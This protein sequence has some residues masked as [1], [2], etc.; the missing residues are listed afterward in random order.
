MDENILDADDESIVN[1]KDMLSQQEPKTV[2]AKQ[3]RQ[4][5]QGA[6]GS[7]K[8]TDWVYEPPLSQLKKDLESAKPFRDSQVTRVNNWE[9][10]REGGAPIAKRRGK[11]A[12][13]PKLVRR[14]AE[15]RYSALSEPFLSSEDV[16]Q[17][18]PR[19]HE[20][21]PAAEQNS[22]L[23][24]WQFRTKMNLVSTIN[25]A[26]RTF[27]DE[28]TLVLKPGWKREVK[29][30]QVMMPVYEYVEVLE[31]SPEEEA[32]K[33]A[34]QL[35]EANPRG[36]NEMDPAIVASIEFS[37]ENGMTA[38]ARKVGENQVDQEKIVIN[39]PTLDIVD[40]RNVYIDPSCGNDADKAAFIVYSFETS[41]AELMKDGRYKNLGVVNYASGEVMSD[42]EHGTSTPQD[43]NFDDEARKR[44][45]AYEYWGLCDINNDGMLVPIVATWID[46]QLIRMEEN[47]YPDKKPPFLF[48]S[49]SPKKKSV[50]G[51]P[52]A[53]LLGDNQAISGA[54]IRGMI[55]LLG[56][57]ANSQQGFQKGM[58]DTTNRR[59]FENGEDYEFNPQANPNQA[60]IQH[61]YP[62]LPGSALELLAQ[63]NAEA[64]GLT[65][66]K[67]FSGGLSGES[68]GTVASGIKGI[69]DAAAKREMDIL[70]RL[71]EIFKRAAIKIIAMNGVFLEEKEVVR[72]TNNKFVVIR[73]DELEGQF[74]LVVDIS[75]PEMDERRAADLA[76]VMQTTAQILP[77]EFTQIL[78]VEI[79]RLR[80][81]PELKHK[82][83]NFVPQP[84]PIEE[85]KKQ[86]EVR[87]LELEAAEIE[88]KIAE[89]RAKTTKLEAEAD[90]I[91][92][93]TEMI[94]SGVAHAQDMEKQTEQSRGNADLAITK[95]MVARKK[96]E[97]QDFDL[98]AAVGFN[99][100]TKKINTATN[101]PKSVIP[102]PQETL[103]PFA[104]LPQ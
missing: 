43:F 68:F 7:V 52:D 60:L 62:E 73:R 99:T 11:S 67:A 83:Q 34:L 35:R 33:Q 85:A 75:T 54:L 37:E 40:Y 59:R 103:D 64:E 1:G 17:V 76:F 94:G 98:E 24:N 89:I 47:P 69:V 12:I 48:A 93:G 3:L 90:R 82:I 16:F 4:Q 53:E 13:R 6:I 26:V 36:F 95:A 42:T 51:E 61:K 92:L 9:Q 32:L 79:A 28:G 72:I 2:N 45:V 102:P 84:D 8:L 81:M 20:D 80:K 41:K 10:L 22:I 78:L 96:P 39:H 66:V 56:R 19:T 101:E 55:D 74:D 44:V 50:Y 23:L 104:I 97:E 65:G 87:K 58:L 46:N 49:Y 57:S 71:A 27:V 100:L 88:A 5:A 70:R 31:G 38:W 15:W 86:L 77:F 30:E 63:Q 25:E 91:D 14:Q 29:Q 18:N 21:G